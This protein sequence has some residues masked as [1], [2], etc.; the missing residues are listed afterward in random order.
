MRKAAQPLC[1]V[2]NCR[3]MQKSPPIFDL[4]TL[5]VTSKTI[6]LFAA[7]RCK[8]THLHEKWGFLNGRQVGLS[9]WKGTC[10]I[11]ARRHSSKS[12]FFT[13]L[14]CA[15]EVVTNSSYCQ[16]Q[17]QIHIPLFRKELAKPKITL[18]LYYIVVRKLAQCRNFYT[19]L[20]SRFREFLA[21]YYHAGFLYPL[22]SW[23]AFAVNYPTINVKSE[24]KVICLRVSR[25]SSAALS[26]SQLQFLLFKASGKGSYNFFALLSTL[27]LRQSDE[28]S[29][30]LVPPVTKV[31][32]ASLTLFTLL[33][34]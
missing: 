33:P 11:F 26:Q 1:I 29:P 32:V 31:S 24:Q 7:Y 19:D 2:N 15:Q 3:F 17:L 28:K 23:S 16:E 5:E 34:T 25:S 12:T 18:V 21:Q 30:V 14:F 27:R 13:P 10:H 8:K 4:I 22:L 9:L 6:W 20:D